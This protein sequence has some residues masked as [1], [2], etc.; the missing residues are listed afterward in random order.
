MRKP[1][2]YYTRKNRPRINP[3]FEK[4]FVS[5]FS[6]KNHKKIAYLHFIQGK[7]LEECA[8]LTNY[9]VRQVERFNTEIKD[10]AIEKLLELADANEISNKLAVIKAIVNDED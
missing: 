9:S 2:I 7:T 8:E 10:I 1:K 6:E 3:K 4:L 5:L